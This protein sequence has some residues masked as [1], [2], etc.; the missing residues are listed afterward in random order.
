MTN[1]KPM[2]VFNADVAE[3]SAIIHRSL[4]E[5]GKLPEEFEDLLTV[6]TIEIDGQTR[7]I[8]NYA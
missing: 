4:V 5:T 6:T 1:T 8:I 2:T 3:F 7:Y